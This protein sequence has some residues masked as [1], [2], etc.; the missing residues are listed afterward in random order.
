MTPQSIQVTTAPEFEPLTL[1]EAR[2]F[3][4]IDDDSQDSTLT[5]CIKA[6]RERIENGTHRAIVTQTI[7]FTLDCFPATYPATYNNQSIGGPP[8]LVPRPPLVSVSSIAYIDTTGTTQTL[9][10]SNY[11][12]DSYSEPGRIVPAYGYSW[13][14]TRDVPNAVTITCICGWTTTTIPARA[15]LLCGLL[16]H[17]EF[18]QRNP[19]NVGNV[20]NEMPMA[21]ESQLN[22]SMV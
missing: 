15:K 2:E 22:F 13:P 21:V 14:S 16:T 9:S 5:I 4:R 8:I 7:R 20:V 18:D 17:Y 1:A 12:V 19:V 10:A 11:T 3:C 6:A